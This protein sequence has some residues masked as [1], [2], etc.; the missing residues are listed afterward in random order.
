MLVRKVVE[1][2]LH[3][4]L[5]ERDVNGAI[6]HSKEVISQVSCL[7]TLYTQSTTC[8]HYYYMYTSLMHVHICVKTVVR[9][10]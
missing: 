9:Y 7:Y 6:A 8:M 10:V 1:T 5:V 4:I 2:C 3:K